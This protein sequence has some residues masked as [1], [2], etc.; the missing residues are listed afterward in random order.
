[1]VPDPSLRLLFKIDHF[2]CLSTVYNKLLAGYEPGFIGQQKSGKSGN[3]FSPADSAN[4]ELLMV[5]P[6][7]M[8]L[9][10]CCFFLKTADI[11]PAGE[12]RIDSDAT[13]KTDRHGMSQGNQ[14]S[15]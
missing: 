13:A 9:L 14:T 7:E 15:F 1:M 10:S 8:H 4:G 2:P 5:F 12:N 11:D 6:G 3:D